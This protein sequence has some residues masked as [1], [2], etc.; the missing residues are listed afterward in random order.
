MPS[1]AA[2]DLPPHV[3]GLGLRERKRLAAMRRIQEVA[4]DLFEVDGYDAVTIERIAAQA[5]V[6]PSSVYRYF[7]SKEGVLL[8][9]EYDPVGLQQAAQRMADEPPLDAIREV[10]RTL[11]VEAVERDAEHL[12]RRVRLTMREPAVKAASVLQTHQL[13]DQIAAM[14]AAARG[15]EVDDL[16]IQVFAHALV[17]A[18]L[19]AIEHW[20]AS[21]FTTSLPD[22]LDLVFARFETG[23]PALT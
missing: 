6:S 20:Y 11:V 23:F 13:G 15:G 12:Q 2:A 16:E 7:G 5:E 22:A 9:D 17:G 19:G 1:D 8:W 21:D 10:F 14:L 18:L 3:A 4:I